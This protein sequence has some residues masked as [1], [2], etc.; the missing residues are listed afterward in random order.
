[1]ERDGHKSLHAN[2]AGQKMKGHA[3]EGMR[4]EREKSSRQRF[5][6][7]YGVV[8]FSIE[9]SVAVQAPFRRFAMGKTVTIFIQLVR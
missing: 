5:S 4:R 3:P 9:V 2:P 8:V 6:P 7:V 1:L